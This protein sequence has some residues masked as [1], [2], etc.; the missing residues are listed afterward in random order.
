[1]EDRV[2]LDILTEK[3]RG[4]ILKRTSG[5]SSLGIGDIFTISVG[6]FLALLEKQVADIGQC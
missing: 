1:M 6:F 3:N 5:L 2:F 4:K